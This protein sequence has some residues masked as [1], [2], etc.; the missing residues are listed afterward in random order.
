MQTSTKDAVRAILKADQSLT[1]QD[2]A[3]ILNSLSRPDPAP[4]ENTPKVLRFPEA[5]R[6]LSITPR[7][8]FYAIRHAGIQTVKLPGRGRAF[9]IRASDLDRL[10]SGECG[11]Q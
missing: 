1:A 6:Q 8:L 11:G 10:V 9:G 5:A 3:K 2:R 7:A 4:R